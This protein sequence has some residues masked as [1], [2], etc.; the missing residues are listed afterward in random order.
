VESRRIAV[1]GLYMGAILHGDAENRKQ[2]LVLLHGF[3]G[4][5]AGWSDLSSG[6]EAPGRWL[7]ALDMPGHGQS[8]APADPARYTM[9]HCQR[10]IL[11]ALAAL[12]VRQGEATLLGY[13]MG[14]RIALYTAF[15]GFFR[16][17]ILESASP[18]LADP[19]ERERR[20][21][22][23]NALAAR[24][25]REGVEAFIDY[26][27]QLPLFASQSNL[28]PERRAA[29]RAQ[30]LT[31]RASGLAN[32]L[33]GVGTGVQPTLHERLGTLNLPVLLLAGELDSKFC[34]I[35][36][37]MARSTPRARLQI[38]PGAGHTI[39]LEQP[40]LFAGLVDEFCN[41][42]YLEQMRR[43]QHAS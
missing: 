33:R 1:N 18:G 36:R 22:S 14:G 3:T 16:A 25:E 26:W 7:I 38:V 43:N 21:Q 11:A 8:D 5:A 39:H 40:A 24:I 35:A 6:L 28:P 17:L 37:Q 9:E 29:L 12:G 13:S 4:C 42:T 41:E 2:T 20:R 27:E 23:D 32:S 15:S 19:A 30:R 31:N 10:D 34:Q